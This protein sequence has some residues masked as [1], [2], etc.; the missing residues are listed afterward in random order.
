MR[1]QLDM[2]LVRTLH[3]YKMPQTFAVFDLWVKHLVLIRFSLS[4]EYLRFSIFDLVCQSVRRV[5]NS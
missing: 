4:D 2:L 5:S 1:T 3:G